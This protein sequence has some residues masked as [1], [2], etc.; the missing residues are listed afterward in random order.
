MAGEYTRRRSL[1][2]TESI[3]T[4]AK[5]LSMSDEAQPNQEPAGSKWMALLA[6]L[7]AIIL[8]VGG[9]GGVLIFTGGPAEPTGPVVSLGDPVKGRQVTLKYGCIQCHTNDGTRAQGPSFKGLFNSTVTY[10]DG[11]T[12]VVNEEDVRYALREPAG[13]VIDGF[14]P[15][16][17]RYADQFTEEETVNL[18]AYLRSIGANP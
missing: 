11:S 3:F 15:Q 5:A 17:P 9:V 12:G 8:L 2:L 14:E 1:A 16:M 10:I 6:L 18:I 7:V 13:K 4:D